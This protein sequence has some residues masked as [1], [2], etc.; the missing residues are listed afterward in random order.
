[1]VALSVM[2]A[3]AASITPA[4]LSYLVWRSE[5]NTSPRSY[6]TRQDVF[7]GHVGTCYAVTL[8]RDFNDYLDM[9]FKRGISGVS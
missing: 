7:H 1:M 5:G 3:P 8:V 9:A 6:R 4:G 2:L